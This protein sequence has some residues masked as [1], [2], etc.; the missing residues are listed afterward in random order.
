MY[1]VGVPEFDEAAPGPVAAWAAWT[2]A[3]ACANADT[4][5]VPMLRPPCL[6]MAGELREYERN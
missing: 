2:A 6:A 5:R 3:A 1:N 4:P